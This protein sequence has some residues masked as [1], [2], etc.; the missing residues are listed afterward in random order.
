MQNAVQDFLINVERSFRWVYPG[1]LLLVLLHLGNAGALVGWNVVSDQ[2]VAIQLFVLAAATVV[3]SF[4][5][6]TVQ[7]YL[8]HEVL[9][10][11]FMF[12]AGF[13]EAFNYARNRRGGLPKGIRRRPWD[14]WEWA[15]K[16]NL[17]SRSI[18]NGFS[19]A[20]DYAWGV[21][22]ALGVTSW[23]VWVGYLLSTT[24]STLRQD[25]AVIGIIVASLLFLVLWLW[26]ECRNV[27]PSVWADIDM[28]TTLVTPPNPPRG[29]T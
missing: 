27:V 7:R 26:Q 29:T 17:A 23:L 10:Q 15:T 8:I 5:L 20:R 21:T 4:I 1:L 16:L 2:K 6:Y 24:G 9:V 3:M 28:I 19:E 18:G 11:Y 14:F 12:V 13:G 22:H 25:G